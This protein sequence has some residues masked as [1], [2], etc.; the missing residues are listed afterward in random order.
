MARNSITSSTYGEST[1]IVN[2]KVYTQSEYKK[3]LKAKGL[4][5]PKKK[6][7][8]SLTDIQCQTID[9]KGLMKEAK[10]LKS[11][12]AYYHNGYRQW[13]RLAKDVIHGNEDIRKPFVRFVSKYDEVEAILPQ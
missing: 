6:V 7:K 13:G 9:I 8:K 3:Y 10:L 4:I 2:G 5:K 11:F 1:I 12:D